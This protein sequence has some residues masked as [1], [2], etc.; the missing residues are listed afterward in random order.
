MLNVHT[1]ESASS[2]W[3][4][5]VLSHDQVIQWT[6]AK[7]RVYSDSVLCLRKMYENKDAITKWE[8][9]VEGLKM[10]PSYQELLRIDGAAIFQDF[11]HCRF[12]RKS[13]ICENGTLN[14]SN[15][16]TGSSSCQCSTA[17]IGQQKETMKFVFRIEK[18]SKRYAKRFLQGHWTFLGP[19]DEQKWYGTLPETPE[20]KWD[21]TATQMVERFKDTGHPV[22]KSIRNPE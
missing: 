1:I 20:G 8:G 3:T 14:L 16:Q 7:V 18:R 22:F 2:S 12:F 19:G 13:R 17:S 4:R 21:S 10:H 15:L 11:R 5:S 6:K 9:Q